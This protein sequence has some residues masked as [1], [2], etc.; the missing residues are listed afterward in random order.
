MPDITFAVGDKVTWTHVSWGS[1]VTMTLRD[2]TIT[3]LDGDVATVQPSSK[4]TR[5]V[6]INIAH[7]RKLGQKTEITEFV[8]ATVRAARAPAQQE[9]T[10]T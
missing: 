8:E 1:T 6:R 3:A 10:T 7:L 4:G 2:G 5:A 9:T